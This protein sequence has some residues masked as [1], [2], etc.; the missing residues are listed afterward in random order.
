MSTRNAPT[1]HHHPKHAPSHASLLNRHSLPLRI[2]VTQTKHSPT[3]I[4]N[5]HKFAPLSSTKS[6]SSAQHVRVRRQAAA[7]P[8]PAST[9]RV[10][11]P[12]GH[13]I[14]SEFHVPPTK[15][16][17]PALL[18]RHS[19]TLFSRRFFPPT[20]ISNFTV[21]FVAQGTRSGSS[22]PKISERRQAL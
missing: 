4:L 1:P 22:H 15:H 19:S 17:P 3:P 14:P 16:S 20:R 5:R 11:I 12:N 18:N 13:L 9:L 8:S 2:P 10:P 6:A 7:L 21:S